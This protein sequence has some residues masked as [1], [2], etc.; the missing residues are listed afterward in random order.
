MFKTNVRLLNWNKFGAVSK[1]RDPRVQRLVVGQIFQR[2]RYDHNTTT[3]MVGRKWKL[4]DT[5]DKAKMESLKVPM[6]GVMRLRAE[7]D[8]LMKQ[9]NQ[10]NHMRTMGS[11]PG[12]SGHRTGTTPQDHGGRGRGGG[13]TRNRGGGRG[14]DF[15]GGRGGGPSLIGKR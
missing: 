6:L 14:G 15:G 11:R 13:F 7:R 1:T 12:Y 3:A 8:G 10:P 5:R 9:R 2:Q 4:P